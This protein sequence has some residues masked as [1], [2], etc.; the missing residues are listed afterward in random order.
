MNL[1]DDLCAAF[2]GALKVSKVPAGYAV[3][4][5]H[6][7]MDGDPVGFYVVGPDAR[8]EYRV[9]DDGMYMTL[10]ESSGGDLSNKTRLAAFNVLREEY[11]VE[12][13]KRSNEL[14]TATVAEGQIGSVALRF[15][16][17]LLRI[18]DLVL[19]SNERAASTFREEATKLLREVVGDRGRVIE[20][21]TVDPRISDVPADLGIISEGRPPVAVFFILS[22]NRLLEALLLQAYAEKEH[23]PCT[24]MA[25]LETDASLSSKMNQ[26]AANHLDGVPIFRGDERAACERIAKAAFGTLLQ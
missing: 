7:G 2:C 14:R 1:Q 24:V 26:R 20:G 8:G 21:Y 4:T 12:F 5:G 25:M 23:V 9:Q 11:A 17:F 6:Q 10:V 13:D 19:M 3:S 18:Q 15:L 16:A 22:D